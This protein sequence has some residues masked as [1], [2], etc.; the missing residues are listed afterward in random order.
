MIIIKNMGLTI[1]IGIIGILVGFFIG[2][3]I[4]HSRLLKA[5][6]RLEEQQKHFDMLKVELDKQFDQKTKLMKEEFQTLSTEILE[7]KKQN[8]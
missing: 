1:I 8:E 4:I 7:R 3:S 2:Y 6:I 5:E